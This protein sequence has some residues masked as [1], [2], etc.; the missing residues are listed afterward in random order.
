MSEDKAQD[1]DLDLILMKKVS[2]SDDHEAFAELVERHQGPVVG[3]IAR[4]LGNPADS[5]DLAQQVFIRIWKARKRYQAKAKFTTYLFTITRNLV[6]NES[7][8][9]SRQKNSS[10]DAAQKDY[11]FELPDDPR[12]EP[13]Q[14]QLRKELIS[15]VNRAIANLPEKQRLAVILRRQENLP[16]DEIAKVLGISISAVK[17]QLFR[18]RGTLREALDKYLDD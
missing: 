14:S 3:T 8:R 2:E 10:L 16:Y 7:R 18:A 9:R 12:Q 11:D 17:S 4:M 15:E 5:E 13:D 1:A 6:F